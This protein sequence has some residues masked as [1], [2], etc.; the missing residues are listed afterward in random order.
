MEQ[1]VDIADLKV[2]SEADTTLVTYS[3]GSCIGVAIW[4]PAAIGR[5]PVVQVATE[6][7]VTTSSSPPTCTVPLFWTNGKSKPL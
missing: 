5:W 1:T 3:L 4:D 7:P 2:S 6:L